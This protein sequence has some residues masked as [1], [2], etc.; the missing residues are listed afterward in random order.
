MNCDE[1]GPLLA[2]L[3]DGTLD[4]A[5]ARRVQAHIEGCDDCFS[6][7][8]TLGVWQRQAEAWEDM[9]APMILL[10]HMPSRRRGWRL[11]PWPTD[12]R[13]WQLLPTAASLGALA[14]ALVAFVRAGS[15]DSEALPAMAATP[16]PANAQVLHASFDEWQQ[17]FQHRL[18][19]DQSLIVQAVMVA[20][21]DRRQRELDALA[22]LL[23][24]EMDRQALETDQSLRYVVAHQLKE[25]ER[26]DQLAVQVQQIGWEPPP[27]L[28]SSPEGTTPEGASP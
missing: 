17:D 23:K 14:L 15:P 18:E 6:L 12:L 9:P 10:P 13:W 2:E 25:Q 11:P 5:V 4:A 7:A 1:A 21:E 26:V 28:L 24:A 8:G 22:R 3:A 16:L 20:N 27:G 19:V